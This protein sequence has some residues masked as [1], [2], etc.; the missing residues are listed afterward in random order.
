MWQRK[1]RFRSVDNVIEEIRHVKSTYGTSQFAFKDDSFTVDKRRVLALCHRMVD[2]KLNVNWDCTTRADLLDEDLLKAMVR[3]GC[4]HVKIGVET[5]S[6]RILEATNKG[7]T[8]DQMRRTA[9]LLNKSKVFW[10]AYFMVGL[11][12]ETE[13]DIM[14]TY[15][16]MKEL[17]PCYAGLGVYS[18]FPSTR[19]FEVGVDMGL[20]RPKVEL[21]HFFKVNPKDYFFADPHKRVAELAPNEFDHLVTF[22]M[23]RFHRHNTKPNN[24]IRRGWA[25][26]LAY[27]HDPKLM[28]SDIKKAL[29]WWL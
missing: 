21:E 24:I 6:Q 5:G 19:L 1:V 10:S 18:A 15:E 12:M 11:P 29:N 26:R 4:N 9:E 23:Q 14:K 13:E 2:E 8:L 22:L 27:C 17:D 28:L 3:A 25:R 7:V 16:F 20:L